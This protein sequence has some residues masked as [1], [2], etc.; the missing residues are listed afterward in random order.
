MDVAGG[1][2][3]IEV[4]CERA[5]RAGEQGQ[6]LRVHGDEKR[7]WRHLDTCQLKTIITAEVP[8]VLDPES[9]KTERVKVPARPPTGLSSPLRLLGGQEG[10]AAGR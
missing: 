4:A 9:G 6:R 10:A 3:R 2:V 5:R 1:E 7:Q 8:R